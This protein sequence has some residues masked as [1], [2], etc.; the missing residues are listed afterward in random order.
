[1]KAPTKIA[2]IVLIVAG[3]L[4][5]TLALR[6]VAHRMQENQSLILHPMPPCPPADINESAIAS[7]HPVYPGGIKDVAALRALIQRDPQIAQHYKDAGF[8]VNCATDEILAMNTW[9]TTSFRS[10]DHFEFTRT[11]VLLLAGEHVV[12]DNC[13]GVIIRGK[14]ANVIMFPEKYP[15]DSTSGQPIGSLIP[16]TDIPVPPDVAF[17]LPPIDVPPPGIPPAP[18]IT[19]PYYPVPGVCCILYPPLP[20]PPTSTSEASSVWMLLGGLAAMFLGVQYFRG[21]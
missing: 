5:L 20:Y 15:E 19:P 2:I 14:C 16:P 17:P 4:A 11:P 1:M 9:S 3:V 12:V 18:P 10:G 13:H 6:S 21:K 8:D 7:A